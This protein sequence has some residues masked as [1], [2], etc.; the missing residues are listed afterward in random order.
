MDDSSSSS[1]SG[2]RG[3]Q[4]RLAG[5]RLEGSEDKAV[6]AT[7]TAAAA[8]DRVPAPAA[9]EAAAGRP[10]QQQQQGQPNLRK[11]IVWECDSCQRACFPI[12]AESRCLCNHRYGRAPWHRSIDRLV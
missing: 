11:K 3:L 6:A 12:R 2:V 7:A 10:M 4:A 9:G 8:H 1:A 5:T